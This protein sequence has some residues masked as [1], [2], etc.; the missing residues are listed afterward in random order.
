MNKFNTSPKCSIEAH[1]LDNFQI[2]H[3]SADLDPE[4][5]P[6]FLTDDPKFLLLFSQQFAVHSQTPNPSLYIRT[7]DIVVFRNKWN[8][9]TLHS[10]G[11]YC[12]V[13]FLSTCCVNLCDIVDPLLRNLYIEERLVSS[14]SFPNS[15]PECKTDSEIE[16]CEINNNVTVIFTKWINLGRAITLRDP[17]WRILAARPGGNPPRLEDFMQINQGPREVFEK[18]FSSSYK[19]MRAH[20]LYYLNRERYKQVKY[21][22]HGNR[23]YY[24]NCM[25]I[26]RPGRYRLLRQLLLH[27]RKFMSENYINTVIKDEFHIYHPSLP[28]RLDPSQ[29]R[30][31]LNR[32]FRP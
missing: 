32:L 22:V 13:V 20:N 27:F 21:D 31:L 17:L 8:S 24:S 16:I 3:C 6:D 19:E 11:T 4:G 14:I 15:C 18:I 30:L 23:W 25:L 9:S 5:V 29:T 7:Q 26:A 2:C 10:D 28:T 12:P 1:S